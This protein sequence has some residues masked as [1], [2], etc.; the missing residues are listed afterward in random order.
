MYTQL[1]L[2]DLLPPSPPLG[3]LIPAPQHDPYWDEINETSD[4]VNEA[5]LPSVECKILGFGVDKQVAPQQNKR[6]GEQLSFDDTP[7]KSVGEQVTSDTLKVAPQHEGKLY[8]QLS[9]ENPTH[10]VEKYWVERGTN[11]YWY[12]RY[13]WMEGRKLHRV[14]IGSITS[15]KAR[16]KKQAVLEAITDGQS[17]QEIIASIRS[18]K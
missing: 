14:Y 16:M 8:T 9:N 4:T 18:C 5:F 11:K 7:Y 13:M 15:N 6:V 2:F 3:S 12:Y 17:P 1:S 10:W